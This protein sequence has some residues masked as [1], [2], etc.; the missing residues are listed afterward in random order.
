MCTMCGIVGYYGRKNASN[1]LIEGLKKL[2]YRGYDSAGIAVINNGDVTIT[3]AVGKIINLDSKIDYS[4]VGN[5]GMGH[6]RWATHGGVNLAN[7]HPHMVNDTVI[8][9]NG[10]LENYSE[11]KEELISLGYEFKS[12]TDTEVLCG[13]IDYM[14][15][16]NN[17]V[18]EALNI[19]NESERQ[20]DSLLELE[21]LRTKKKEKD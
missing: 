8:V 13:Y 20:K 10:I 5:I 19:D 14:F 1:I 2:E 3:K 7:C 9:H 4:M 12:D 6:T 17:D 21:Q 18:I 16:N 15:K 11:L